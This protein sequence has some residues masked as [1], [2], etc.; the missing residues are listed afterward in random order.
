[1]NASCDPY[2]KIDIIAKKNG[3]IIFIKVKTYNKKFLGTPAK[4][5][6]K[7][8]LK[9]LKTAIKKYTLDMQVNKD[10]SVDL[11]C[12]YLQPYPPKFKHFKCID[13]G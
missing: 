6:D 11:I 9:K 7:N 8:K 4:N 1:M 13:L 5:F 12:V 2:G 3:K 10:I